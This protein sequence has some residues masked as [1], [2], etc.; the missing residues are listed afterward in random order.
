[1]NRAHTHIAR[2]HTRRHI[3]PYSF[4]AIQREREREREREEERE[5]ERGRDRE[6]EREREALL[7]ANQQPNNL[8]LAAD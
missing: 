2:T 7:D 4:F 8:A 1:V 5:R 3:P 6:R